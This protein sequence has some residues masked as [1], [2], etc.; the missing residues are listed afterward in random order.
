MTR[1][2]N[3]NEYYEVDEEAMVPNISPGKNPS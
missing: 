3:L 2:L 1:V